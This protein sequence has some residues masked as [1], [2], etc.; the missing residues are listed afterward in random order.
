AIKRGIEMKELLLFGRPFD[1]YMASQK[2][3]PNSKIQKK[4]SIVNCQS[5][6][7]FSGLPRPSNYDNKV[8]EWMDDKRILKKYFIKAGLPAPKGESCWN[9]RHAKR[10]FESISKPVVVKPRAG[11]RGRHSTTFVNNLENLKQAFLIAKKLCFWVIVEEQL[12]GPVYRATLINF[13]LCGVLRGDPPQVEGDGARNIGELIKIKNSQPH[14]GVKDVVVDES[15]RLFLSR[16]NFTLSSIPKIGETVNLSEKIGVNYGG[17]SS[18]D[19]EICHTDNKELFIRAAKVLGDP[20]VG[21]DF[22]IPNIAKSWKEQKCG[23]IEANS[24]PFIN[25]HHDPLLGAPRNIAAA[26]WNMINW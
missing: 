16:Q 7:V 9:F 25:L 22:I 11:S 8:L 19:F 13:E 24:L 23:F 10:I 21:F 5:S 17:S 2:E 6:I 20:I 4:S 12:L 15:I 14:P 3:N 26:V 18:E 1:V